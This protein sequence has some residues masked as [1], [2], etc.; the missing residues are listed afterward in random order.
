[1]EQAASE[2]GGSGQVSAATVRSSSAMSLVAREAVVA[3]LDQR[4]LH[5]L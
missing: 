4:D 2:H 3:A 1:M 5:V